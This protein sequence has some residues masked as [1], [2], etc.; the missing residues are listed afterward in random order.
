MKLSIVLREY[1]QILRCGL[2]LNN[3]PSGPEDYRSKPIIHTWETVE[4]CSL[5]T[6]YF[7]RRSVSTVED[8]VVDES[9]IYAEHQHKLYRM[10]SASC[11][12]NETTHRSIFDQNGQR[13]SDLSSTRQV[14]GLRVFVPE[15]RR[16]KITK[17]YAGVTAN[18]YGA[19][20]SAEGNYLHWFV[21]CLSRLFLIERLDP[22]I[23]I[24]YVLVPPLKYDFQ[25][26]SLQALGF[27]R[28]QIIELKPLQCF[29][30]ENLLATTAPRG[31]G[32]AIAPKWAIDRY[33]DEFLQK[34]SK[35]PR[36]VGSRIYVSRRDAP[37]RMFINEEAVCSVMKMHGFDV[38]ELTPLNLW[39]K[40]AVFAQAEIIVSQTG[41]GLAN[42][43]FCQS[44]TKVLE[45]VDED[46]VYPLYA[47]LAHSVNSEHDVHFFNSRNTSES[48]NP[49]MA[50]A[51]ID[52][53]RLEN[54]IVKLT[55]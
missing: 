26:E 51:L 29:Q 33:R 46:F 25:W 38:V 28:A 11:Y 37:N 55:S 42:L 19:V 14:V 5:D 48:W 34:A 36:V 54:S 31:L 3:V 40:I 20:A 52:I 22:S 9:H 12:T 41:A 1:M 32:S 2:L 43:M 13:V 16:L 45:L 49:M 7:F 18:L 6:S 53:D 4:S 50:K 39:Q 35:C 23:K 10:K 15:T 24:S 17:N 47:T 44:G 8:R 21:D 27:D 30:F